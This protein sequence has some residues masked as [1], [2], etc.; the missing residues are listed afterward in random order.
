[1][2][3]N[4]SIA[5][6]IDHA[7]LHPTMQNDQLRDGCQIAKKLG[8][9]SVC[10]KPYAVPLAV[11]LLAGSGVRVGT[12]I[13]FPH[14]GNAPET[15]AFEADLACQQGAVELDMVVNIAKVLDQDWH[16]VRRD[17]QAVKDVATRHRAI[18]KVIFETDYVT[19]DDLKTRLCQ[20]CEDLGVD[21]VK[22]STGFGFVK[23]PSG[24]YNYTGA[25]DHDIRL[26]RSTCGSQV[27]VKASGGVRNFDDAVRFREL[28][29]TRL[30][31]SASETICTGEQSVQE[32]Y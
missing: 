14:G 28:G 5:K 31:S 30:G 26:M 11:E 9:A 23:Q 19:Q 4:A 15:K 2:S 27:G 8:V 13:G 16:F 6:L 25:T 32:G 7:L 21:Y 10:I 24:D 18:L 22:T 1:M 20:I 29:A 12:V 3:T 17:I